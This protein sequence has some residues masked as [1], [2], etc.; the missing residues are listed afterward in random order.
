MSDQEVLCALC[1]SCGPT[2]CEFREIYVTPGD[3]G[4]IEAFS[5][6]R[7]FYEFTRPADPAYGDQDDD[8]AWTSCVFRTDGTRRVLRQRS[9]GACVFLGRQGCVLPTEVRP[10]ICR[11]HPYDYGERGVKDVL[12]AECPVHLLPP[13]QALIAALGMSLKDARRWHEQLYQ[14]I[15]LER[16]MIECTSV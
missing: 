6:R 2:C 1:A 16:G 11:L 5:G 9:H 15:R 14:E 4:R 10:L 8:P 13:G 12:V 3:V 7:E